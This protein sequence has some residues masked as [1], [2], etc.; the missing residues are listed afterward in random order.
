MKPIVVRYIFSIEQLLKARALDRSR[1]SRITAFG[2]SF[3]TAILGIGLA[4]GAISGSPSPGL[5]ERIT[6]GLF[7]LG[8]LATSFRG[9]IGRAFFCWWNARNAILNLWIEFAADEAS[10]EVKVHVIQTR[11]AWELLR[12]AV[13]GR[14]G[15]LLYQRAGGYFW[16]PG[17][18][19]ESGDGPDR[20]A[21]LLS[22]TGVRYSRMGRCT[23]NGKP[24]SKLNPDEL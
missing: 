10:I 15:F 6:S 2:V 19:F 12:E 16:L 7:S 4:V 21:E 20:L 9:P 1:S 8:L 5:R 24:A 3:L 14:E 13:E 17:D 22:A 18:G 11:L 23:T